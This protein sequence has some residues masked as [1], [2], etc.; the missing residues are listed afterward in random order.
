MELEELEASSKLG[1]RNPLKRCCNN[2]GPVFRWCACRS[3]YESDGENAIV[4]QAAHSQL[5]CVSFGLFNRQ[6]INGAISDILLSFDIID[7]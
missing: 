3:V 1:E 7:V 4:H 2:C 5:Q 6:T